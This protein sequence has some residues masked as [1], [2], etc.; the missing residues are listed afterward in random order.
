MA[1]WFDK[2]LVN[3]QTLIDRFNGIATALG[4]LA[5]KAN[6][7]FTGTVTTAGINAVGTVTATTFSGPLT[8]NVTGNLSGN[9]TTATTANTA[10][11]ATTAT[12]AGSAAAL[13]AGAHL[14]KLNGIEAGATANSSD[15]ALISRAN[16]TGTQAISTIVNLQTTLD[17]KAPLAAPTITGTLTLP[18]GNIE[19]GATAGVAS[20]P[21][22][23]FHSGATATGYDA[24]IMGSGGTGSAGGGALTY[25]AATH[26]FSG[27]VVFS[28]SNAASDA[29]AATAGVPIGGLYRNGSVVQVRVS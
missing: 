18:G 8:G 12:T 15:A 9:A 26:T 28:L 13:S 5:P 4:L 22:F 20:T 3:G 16:H 29:A 24:R 27:K 6:P 10:T 11:T 25:E 17:A 19:F 21:T 7:L 2:S 23:D 14:T 1:T